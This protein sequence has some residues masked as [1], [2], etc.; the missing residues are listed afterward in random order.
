MARGRHKEEY[1][2][3]GI[4]GILGSKP[5]AP[6]LIDALKRLEYRGYDSSGIAIL[7]NSQLTRIRAEGKLRNLEE[8]QQESSLGGLLGIGH[9]RW[10]THGAPTERNAHPH[11]TDKVALVH[12]GIIENYN[13][14]KDQLLS[15]GVEFQSDT[16]TEVVAH[17][18]SKELEKGLT[19]EQSTQSV[20]KKIEGA[21]ALAIIFKGYDDLMIIARQGS[22]LAIGHGQEEMFIG[23][24]AIALAPFTDEITYL[25]DG[26]WAI[27]SRTSL[28]II[29]AD[30]QL[31]Q[32]GKQKSLTSAYVVDK[33][34]YRH[35][36]SKEIHEQPETPESYTGKLYRHVIQTSQNAR[37][38]F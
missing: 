18:I 1:K 23:S 29:D 30:G 9:T 3:C 8:V 2:M 37:V 20:L 24:D 25:E 35:F 19:P 33:G 15:E 10:A 34:N 31:V 22:P 27:L 16:D 28:K 5:V 14:L 36:M 13:S 7:E 4:V 6:L 21:F 17:L 12:N 38:F 26:D 11:M 32:R